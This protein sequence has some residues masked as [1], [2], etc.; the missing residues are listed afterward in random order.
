MYGRGGVGNFAAS[1][2]ALSQAKEEK[3]DEE[4]RMAEDLRERAEH[5][6]ENMLKPPADAFLAGARRRESAVGM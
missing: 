5:D 3:I 2:L 4:R 6:V 1:S